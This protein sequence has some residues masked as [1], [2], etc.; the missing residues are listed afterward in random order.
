[1]S[2]LL[3]SCHQT[4]ELYD[5]QDHRPARYRYVVVALEE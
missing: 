1:L 4:G 2:V 3:A 5:G